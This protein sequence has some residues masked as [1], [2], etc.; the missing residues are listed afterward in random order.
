MEEAVASQGVQ[1]KQTLHFVQDNV[2]FEEAEDSE[3]ISSESAKKA[4]MAE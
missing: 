3:E 4:N 1:D 2:V